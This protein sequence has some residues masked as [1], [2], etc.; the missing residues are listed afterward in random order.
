MDAHG[1]HRSTVRSLGIGLL[2]G[3]AL[4]AGCRAPDGRALQKLACE[5]AAASL[6]LQSVAQLDAL[7]KALGV[8]P[9]VDPIRSCQALGAEMTPRQ[10]PQPSGGATP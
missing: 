9:E 10:A 1:R 8:A 6:D 3:T 2:L 7:R 4:L 5:Q